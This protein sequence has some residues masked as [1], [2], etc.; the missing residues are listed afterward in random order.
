MT[1]LV[2]LPAP[3]LTEMSLRS[4]ETGTSPVSQRSLVAEQDLRAKFLVILLLDALARESPPPAPHSN[5]P[6]SRSTYSLNLLFL[7]INSRH[8]DRA[9]LAHVFCPFRHHH[10]EL[11]EEESV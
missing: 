1:D 6:E 3:Y 9:E 10:L 4:R 5:S 7:F 11:Q 2:Q 8:S